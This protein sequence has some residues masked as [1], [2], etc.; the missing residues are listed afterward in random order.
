[1]I[2]FY[3]FISARTWLA[4]SNKLI[5]NNDGNCFMKNQKYFLNKFHSLFLY[6]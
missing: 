5:T 2:D 4:A 1:M 3:N 6:N